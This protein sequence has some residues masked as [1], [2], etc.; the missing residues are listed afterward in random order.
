MNE[1]GIHNVGAPIVRTRH[2]EVYGANLARHRL[3]REGLTTIGRD[4][5][6]KTDWGDEYQV[7]RGVFLDGWPKKIGPRSGSSY[8]RSDGRIARLNLVFP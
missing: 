6:S 1:I 7:N 8:D 5:R 4:L 3:H 2:S